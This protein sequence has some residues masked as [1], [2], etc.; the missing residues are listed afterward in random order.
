MSHHAFQGCGRWRKTLVEIARLRRQ[1]AQAAH[2]DD[3]PEWIQ[4]VF[5]SDGAISEFDDDAWNETVAG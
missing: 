1:I 2:G 5:G 4:R 3:V